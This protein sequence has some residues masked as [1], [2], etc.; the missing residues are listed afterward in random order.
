MSAQATRV[1]QLV[2]AS[3]GLDVEQSRWR[4]LTRQISQQ[5]PLAGRLRSVGGAVDVGYLDRELSPDDVRR[6]I[7]EGELPLVLLSHDDADVIVLH[8]KDAGDQTQAS[9][10][11]RNGVT[12]LLEATPDQLPD[13]VWKR[14]GARET[15]RALAP[16]ALR[17]STAAV[18]DSAPH[19]PLGHGHPDGDEEHRTPVQRTFAL[20]ARERREI[21]TV[22]FYATLAGGLSLILPLAVGGIVQLVQGRLFLQPVIVLI[23]FV[24]LGTI[25]AGVLQIG[26]LKVVERIQQRV[27]ARMALEFAFRVPRMKYSAS[28]EQNLP[29]QMNRLFEAV[30]IQKGVQKLLIDVPTAVLTVMFGLIL[31]T[32]YSPWFSLFAVVV[33][34]ILYLII[35]WTGP[36]GL[37]TSIVES[38]YKY[39]AVHWLEEIARA[40]HAFK[41]AGDSTLPVERMDDVITGYLKYRKKHFAVLVKQTIALIGFKTFITAAVLIL[42]ATLVQTNRLLLGQ[43]VAAEVVI[44]TVL[45]GIEK[46]ITSLATVYDVLTSVDKSGHVAD[47]PLESRGGLAPIHSPGVGIAIETRELAYR[48]PGAPLPSVSGVTLRIAPG[49][50]VGIMGVDGSGRSTLLKLL[51]SLIDDYDGT[52]RYDGITLRDLDRPAL[53]SRI[54][55][56]LSWT[57]LFD[58]SV[59]ENVSVGRAHIT[60]L[61]VRAALDDLQLTDEIQQLPQ[62]LQTELTNGA[63]NL[64][65]H[66]A[67]KLLIAQGIVGNPRLVV[68]DDFFQNLDASSRSLIIRLLTD[69]SRAWTVLAV[70][71]DPLLL[72]EFDRVVV[73]HGGRIVR[74][75]PFQELRNDPIC[76]TLLHETLTLNGD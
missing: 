46:L 49:E 51:A 2:T 27:F 18:G 53:R 57:D 9:V 28:M 29:E 70:S 21:M 30:A 5:D 56:M 35:K 64:P 55:Q 33:L 48:Y 73:V 22:F 76:R 75:G 15:V 47:L 13:M 69:R 74:E 71:N 25:V 50:R 44:V 6:A 66:L 32:V 36:E 14:L 43:F 58:G 7:T 60:P 3:L 8:R 39:K 67:N 34:F 72:A 68:F 37:A 63:R 54:G 20:M 59:E 41:Y 23:S 42:G 40:V 61:D 4:A 62:G 16:M 45:A 12:T 1:N 10:V 26:I 31:L 17:S 11:T 52:I 65:T 19:S 24:I 38:K